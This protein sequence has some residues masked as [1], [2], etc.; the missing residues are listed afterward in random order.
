MSVAGQVIAQV[1][2]LIEEASAIL[3]RKD[4]EQDERMDEIEKRLDALESPAAR[5]RT[6]TAVKVKAG[7]AR[8]SGEA[9]SA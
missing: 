2:G 3:S 5:T 9:P 4:T 1:R 6:A 7:T 8:G